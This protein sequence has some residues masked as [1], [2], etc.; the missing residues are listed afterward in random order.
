MPSGSLA[1]YVWL[2]L[3]A[4]F[5]HRWTSAYGDDPRGAAGRVWARGLADLT[6]E[7]IDRGIVA[8][9]NGV[10]DW[11]PSLPDFRA[12]CLGVLSFAEVLLDRERRA[13]FTAML[14][15][16]LDGYAYRQASADRG[17]RLLREAYDVARTAVLKGE[18]MPAPPAAQLAASG[19][20][21][22]PARIAA[23]DVVRRESAKVYQL[24]GRSGRDAAAGPDR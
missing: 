24:L 22:R 23:P 11:P 10:D 21:W 6:R 2:S 15:R 1:D 17:E 5:G 4:A 3:G 14:W 20:S 13:P 18:P 12:K 9:V 8:S 16:Y 7:Q 19:S